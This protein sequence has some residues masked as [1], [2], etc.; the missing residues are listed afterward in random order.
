MPR[1]SAGVEV[2]HNSCKVPSVRNSKIRLLGELAHSNKT[3]I[4]FIPPRNP[5][6]S[7][8]A[9]TDSQSF[10]ALGISPEKDKCR[11]K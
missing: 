5:Q 2:T 4:L 3:Y 9:E 11:L 1:L 7:L 8:T 6:V 10:E